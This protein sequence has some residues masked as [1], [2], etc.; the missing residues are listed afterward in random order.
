MRELFLRYVLVVL[1][2]SNLI[3]ILWAFVPVF[4][5]SQPVIFNQPDVL[6]NSA[7]FEI[8]NILSK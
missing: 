5:N 1:E 4:P 6:L 7:F 8:T 2:P 3:A